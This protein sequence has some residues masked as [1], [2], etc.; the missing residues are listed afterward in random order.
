MFLFKFF[1]CVYSIFSMYVLV[2]SIND[3]LVKFNEN[4]TID[5]FDVIIKRFNNDNGDN[6]TTEE[7]ERLINIGYING[8]EIEYKRFLDDLMNQI[9]KRLDRKTYENYYCGGGSILLQ[10]YIED[11]LQPNGKVM[12]NALFSNVNGS[13]EIIGAIKSNGRSK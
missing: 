10:E 2:F 12:P 8:V 9:D 5:L 1:S 13:H 11:Y 4:R 6:K 7:C 3:I